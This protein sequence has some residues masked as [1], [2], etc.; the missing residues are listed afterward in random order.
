MGVDMYPPIY[1]LSLEDQFYYCD[2]KMFQLMV[3]L[4]INDSGSYTFVLR[5][6]EETEI[7][8]NFRIN[9]LV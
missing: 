5:N 2:P 3:V 9:S 6:L 1:A 8:I 4:M 7:N